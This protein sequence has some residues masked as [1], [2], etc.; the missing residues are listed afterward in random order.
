VVIVEADD[1]D[2]IFP[3]QVIDSTQKGG[4]TASGVSGNA[5]QNHAVWLTG[6]RFPLNK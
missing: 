3:E 6:H 1:S 2:E 5:N 4:F